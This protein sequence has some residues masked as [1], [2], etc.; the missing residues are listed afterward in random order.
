MEPSLATLSI[1]YFLLAFFGSLGVLQLAGA[2]SGARHLLLLPRRAHSAVLG[3]A[4]LVI[5]YIIF[6]A[7]APYGIPGVRGIQL[8]PIMEA[9]S[10]PRYAPPWPRLEGAQLFFLFGLAAL[11]AVIVCATI[12]MLHSGHVSEA[13]NV[14][15]RRFRSSLRA[16]RP[17]FVTPRRLGVKDEAT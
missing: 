3:A 10:S 16:L 5:A 11:S 4:L 13:G 8:R 17:L 1:N 14:L 6:F 12:S 9:D 15:R 2:R 7:R